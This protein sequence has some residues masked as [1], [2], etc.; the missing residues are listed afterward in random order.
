VTAR[1]CTRHLVYTFRKNPAI[2]ALMASTARKLAGSEGQVTVFGKTPLHAV[3]VAAA[4]LVTAQA[5]QRFG[6]AMR[7]ADILPLYA[8]GEE[9]L[10]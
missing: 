6:A 10:T 8:S 7:A 9:R 3:T 1:Q 5:I 2:S 4:W